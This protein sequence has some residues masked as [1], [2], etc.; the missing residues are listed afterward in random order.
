MLD[1]NRRGLWRNSNAT[2]R[3]SI[4]PTTVPIVVYVHNRPAYLR[5]V[6]T[7]L[8]RVDG[9]AESLLIVSHDGYFPEVVAVVREFTF[10]RIKQ[11][12]TSKNSFPSRSPDD[13]PGT[14]SPITPAPDGCTGD[15][16]QYDNFRNPFFVGL[17]HH[18]FW[19]MNQVWDEME[20][21]QNFDGHICFLEEDHLVVPNAYRT[22]QV[23]IAVKNARC[24]DCVAVS[25]STGHRAHSPGVLG[26]EHFVA[27]RMSNMGYAFN[28]TVWRRI[29]AQARKFC[30]FDDYGWDWTLECAVMA[31]WAPGT[32]SLHAAGA[33]VIHAGRVTHR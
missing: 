17:K 8:S 31:S 12:T 13:C 23:L 25:L 7:R 10:M 32:L 33:S 29:K 30:G 3:A 26:G 4:T 20:E 9:I 24:P 6:L 27:D 22:L 18:W 11:R 2:V 5:E 14:P 15:S 28:R 19:L 16:D 21:F 1:F